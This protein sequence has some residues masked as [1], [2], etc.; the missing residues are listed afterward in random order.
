MAVGGGAGGGKGKP[1]VTNA[2]RAGPNT[3]SSIGG[4]N[5]KASRERSV[6]AKPSDYNGA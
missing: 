2:P 6:E 4:S 1:P 5:Q 3:R